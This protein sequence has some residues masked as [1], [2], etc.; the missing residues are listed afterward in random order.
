[1]TLELVPDA[2]SRNVA[3]FGK[4]LQGEIA[5]LTG[6]ESSKGAAA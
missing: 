1:M 6:A 5:Q 3:V 2:D 4:W